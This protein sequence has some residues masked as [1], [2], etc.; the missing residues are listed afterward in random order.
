MNSNTCSHS[1][2]GGCGVIEPWRLKADSVRVRQSACLW[3]DIGLEAG[4]RLCQGQAKCM[5]VGWYRAGG[6]FFRV[7]QSACLWGDRGLEAGGRS[8][9]D[10]ARARQR[11]SLWCEGALAWRQI[12]SG[13][14]QGRQSASLWFEGALGWRQIRS[15]L[16][17]DV[18][19]AHLWG[20][21]AFRLEAST[22]A[23]CVSARGRVACGLTKLS[24]ATAGLRMAF[25]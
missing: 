12:R 4:G 6:K 14:Y 15:G 25:K 5:P 18:R 10:S 16:C 20:E 19:C 13:L 21:P 2:V 7:R 3:G 17:Q 11:A 8:E 9:V 23:D 22:Q 1:T 24:R